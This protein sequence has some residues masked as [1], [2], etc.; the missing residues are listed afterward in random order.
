MDELL[1][2]AAHY[3][4]MAIEAMGLLVVAVGS[5][6]AFVAGTGTML[7]SPGDAAARQGVWLRFARWLVFGL[8]LQLAA[9]IIH[10]A[11]APSWDE[12]G[13]LA[14]I[15]AIRTFLNYFLER[16]IA[17]IRARQSA[18]GDAEVARE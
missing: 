10:T 12:I 5:L 7:L 18:P 8:T 16:D 9:D 13:H 1:E 17:E 3:A 14:T 6:E 2:T 11:V 4:A 15:A